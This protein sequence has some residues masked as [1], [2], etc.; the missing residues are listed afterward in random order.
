[1]YRVNI[2]LYKHV[3]K[4]DIGPDHELYDIWVH[5]K[6]SSI[7]VGEYQNL[8]EAQQAMDLMAGIPISTDRKLEN[9]AGEP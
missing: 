7:L 4:N 5:Q 8:K 9:S 6:E 1:M 3:D 2:E